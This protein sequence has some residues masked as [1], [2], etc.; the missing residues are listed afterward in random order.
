L[1][2]APSFSLFA[3]Q[4]LAAA[5][6]FASDAAAAQGVDTADESR[7][8]SRQV[9]ALIKARSFNEAEALANKG[10]ALCENAVGV[11]GFCLGQFN[12]SLGDIAYATA[13]YPG[14]LVFYQRAV[15][16]RKGLLDSS[17]ALAL[18]SQL[19]LGKTYLALHRADDAEPLLKD[20]VAGLSHIAPPSP[21]LITALD[22]LRKL[23]ADTGRI[24]EEVS[25]TRS[26]MEFREKAGASDV[27]ALWRSRLFLNTAL[28][29]QAKALSA[30][31]NDV[32]AEKALIEAIKLIDPP[33][34][35][36]EK[37]L[38]VSLENLAVMYNRLRRYAE[39]ETPFLRA[40]E[41]REKLA[42]PS[43]AN[44]PNL[45][46]NIAVLYQNWGRQDTSVQYGLRAVAKFDEAKIQNSNLGFALYRLGDAQKALGQ[47]AEAERS[48]LRAIDVLD[49]VLPE[50]DPQRINARIALGNLQ[51][52]AERYS[53][54]ERA[55]NAALD[56]AQKY[57][58]PD[59]SWRSSALASLGMLYR[60][61]VKFDDAER[62]VLQAVK[63]EEAAGHDRT[64]FLAQRLTALATILRREN[65]F[66]EAES[67]LSR[68]LTLDQPELDRATTLNSL[69]VIYTSTAR[70]ELAE[71]LLREALVIREKRLPS[72]SPLILETSLNLTSVDTS[73][74]HFAEAEAKLRHTLEI[75]DALGPS[76]SVTIA[77]HSAYLADTLISEGKLDEAEAL[78][79]RSV[80]LYQQRLGP[81]NPRYGGALKVMASIES[82]SWT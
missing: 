62:M 19:R 56:L 75:A 59:T 16:A 61:Q 18:A 78:I 45:L 22:Y 30:G 51:L 34:P 35:G 36:S 33:Q 57:P 54:A 6:L 64:S 53:E 46:F 7:A 15:E 11:R 72:N 71:P 76:H 24:D 65:R 12:D 63:L 60:E 2:R 47:F 44:L 37:Y 77:L 55:L 23:Y 4:F 81:D 48:I 32:D 9:T 39:A 52:D 3:R 29:R 38:S 43:D 79:R 70:Y 27:Q 17:N 69:A 26:E 8:I 25:V 14:A 5:L 13:Q 42:E 21:N 10:L 67:D 41:Y 73:R 58:N 68:A 82:P 50:N 40:L 28:V 66:A 49:R 80:E 31:N 20:A 1:R 74:G